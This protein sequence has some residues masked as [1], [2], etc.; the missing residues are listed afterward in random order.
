M[1]GTVG[2]RAQFVPL[3]VANLRIV[4]LSGTGR[5]V[6]LLSEKTGQLNFDL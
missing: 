5:K 2:T 3:P 1:C 6:Q 4:L